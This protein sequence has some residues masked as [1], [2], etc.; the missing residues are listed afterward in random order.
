MCYFIEVKQGDK[1]IVVLDRDC[2]N[3]NCPT[4]DAK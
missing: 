4:S 1:V 3:P 2:G